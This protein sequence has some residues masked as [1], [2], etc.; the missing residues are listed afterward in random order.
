MEKTQHQHRECNAAGDRTAHGMFVFGTS[1]RGQLG[2]FLAACCADRS[3]SAGL[4]RTAIKTHAHSPTP[5]HMHTH[6]HMHTHNG[7]YCRSQANRRGQGARENERRERGGGGGVVWCGVWCGRTGKGER[8]SRQTR[9][10]AG[11]SPLLFASL[12]FAAEGY[13]GSVRKP[14]SV[15]GR[16]SL[17]HHQTTPTHP[18]MDL[19]S[20]VPRSGRRGKLSFM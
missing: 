18:P 9:T 5:P 7:R 8:K 15:H 1:R 13:T 19:F 17:A 14:T 11:P 16:P 6:T 2:R 10:T 12:P 4:S 20:L 3:F